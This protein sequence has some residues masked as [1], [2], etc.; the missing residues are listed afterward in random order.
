MSLRQL[1][2]TSPGTR[3]RRAPE[4]PEL[5]QGN[6]PNKAL[7]KGK[8]RIS[9]R[10]HKG[11]ITIRHRGGGHRR[12]YREIDF[13]RNKDGIPAKV[14]SIEYDPNRS[15]HIALLHYADGEKRY[16]LAP[17]GLSVGAT[18]L[19]GVGA[20][21]RLGNALLL[22]SI[23]LGT[24]ICC[25]EMKPEKGAQLARKASRESLFEPFFRLRNEVGQIQDSGLGLAI[26][27]SLLELHGGTVW[28]E[29]PV[30]GGNTFRVSL[31]VE[32][33]YEGPGS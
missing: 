24:P 22:R 25:I 11:R 3:F 27:R 18:L 20:E 5:S 7:T 30:S 32:H 26:A 19:S 12:R 29:S 16:I 17:R 14:H 31:P 10:N 33:D 28:L 1:K 2:P 15:A 8:K 9:G 21:P 6:K 4:Y 23:P 13:R